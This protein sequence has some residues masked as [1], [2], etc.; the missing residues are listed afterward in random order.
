MKSTWKGSYCFD[1]EIAGALK[2]KKVEIT[3]NLDTDAEGGI[4]GMMRDADY[5]SATECEAEISGFI[6][7]GFVS[8]VAKFPSRGVYD[9]A[10]VYQIDPNLQPF[11]MTFY[12]DLSED[13]NLITGTWEVVEKTVLDMSEVQV[14]YSGGTFDL[15]KN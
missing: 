14:F 13:G 11:E 4:T 3:L 12:G 6:D 10:L 1:P 15:Q 2:D 7:E 8:L 9:Q 5:F